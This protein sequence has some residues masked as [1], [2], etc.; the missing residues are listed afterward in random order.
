MKGRFQLYPLGI[1]VISGVGAGI[2]FG[3]YKLRDAL[4]VRNDG[5]VRDHKPISMFGHLAN[6]E[7]H[8]R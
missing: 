2:A 5:F 4:Q 8:Q 1:A 6:A 7:P 3:I